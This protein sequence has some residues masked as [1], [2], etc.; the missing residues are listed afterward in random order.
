MSNAKISNGTAQIISNTAASITS[1]NRLAARGQPA[2]RGAGGAANDNGGRA[3]PPLEYTILWMV[4]MLA[5]YIGAPK[6]LCR[7]TAPNRGV[8]QTLRPKSHQSVNPEPDA[9]WIF[10]IIRIG[11]GTYRE[12]HQG[13]DVAGQHRPD[14]IGCN[15]WGGVRDGAA[16]QRNTT[17]RDMRKLRN[18]PATAPAATA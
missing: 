17:E 14:K 9:G 12:Y 18:I 10:L 15:Q 5:S 6:S 2:K 13:H 11:A 4:L 3:R 8:T 16:T 7:T 1:C